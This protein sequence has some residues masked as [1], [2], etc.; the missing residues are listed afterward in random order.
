MLHLAPATRV[1]TLDEKC[2]NRR[3]DSACNVAHLRLFTT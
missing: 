2:L 1:I 3:L